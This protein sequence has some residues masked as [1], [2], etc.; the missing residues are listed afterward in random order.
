MPPKKPKTA[1]EWVRDYTEDLQITTK[2]VNLENGKKQILEVLHCK[3]CAKE[4]EFTSHISNRISEHIKSKRH[5]KLKTQ[6]NDRQKNG[7]QLT[8]SETFVNFREKEKQGESA[9]H[10]FVYALALSA[11]PI[12][13]SMGPLGKVFR[14]WV[15]SARNMP[16]N[17]TLRSDYLPKVFLCQMAFIKN[18]VKDRKFSV[19]IDESPDITGRKTVNTLISFYD[20][21]QRCKRVTL[22]DCSTV[23]RVNAGV[24]RDI[25]EKS[26]KKVEKNW[27]DVLTISSDSASYMLRFFDSL[28]DENEKIFHIND[29]AH[30]IHNS[31]HNAFTLS[32]MSEIRQIIIKFGNLF[33]KANIL[34][35]EFYHILKENSIKEKIPRKTIDHRWFSYYYTMNDIIDL[36]PYLLEFIDSN[37]SQKIDKLKSLLS[38]DTKRQKIHAI[39]RN[40]ILLLKPILV[41]QNKFE[42]CRANS[43]EIYSL[44]N[45]KL[46][47]T[48]QTP[49]PPIISSLNLNAQKEVKSLL[50]IFQNAMTLKWKDT[51]DR[52]CDASVFA[53]NG[54]L[55]KIMI[56]DPFKKCQLTKDFEFYKDL[57]HNIHSTDDSNELIIEF[58]SYINSKMPDNLDIEPL[59]FWK[60]AQNDYPILS[61]IAIEYLCIATNSL[62][63]ERSFSK[64]RDVQNLKRCKMTP[65]TLSMQMILY[66]NGDLENKLNY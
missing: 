36:W 46:L 28:K 44:A 55:Y 21:I 6:E 5:Q 23:D 35:S 62:D 1:K 38:G 50:K 52:N 58:N 11:S 33:V 4:F 37:K 41:I 65:E 8:I 59:E 14:K 60:S 27:N 56:F 17:V 13:K 40:L 24:I 29:I 2:N 7:K 34:R 12:N 25:M 42:N 31:V 15:P 63:A 3:F 43:H 49:I 10:D 39:I 9:C 57:F 66:F 64:L 30:L 47:S 26:I 61:R 20:K 19:I 22:I 48:I 51:F 16:S 18:L 54:F 53:K 32:E 45:E